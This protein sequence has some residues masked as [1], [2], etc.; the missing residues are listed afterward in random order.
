MS[1]PDAKRDA[2]VETTNASGSNLTFVNAMGR[3]VSCDEW[4]FWL[5][6]SEPCSTLR[7]RHERTPQRSCDACSRTAVAF[8]GVPK[9]GSSWMQGV[10]P[11]IDQKLPR[12]LGSG[13]DD[14]YVC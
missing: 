6:P 14:G 13:S 2:R 3:R 8:V 7:E 12:L 11:R 10:D 4:A 9:S 5:I 1:L